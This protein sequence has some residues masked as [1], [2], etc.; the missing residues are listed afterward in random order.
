MKNNKSIAT[1]REFDRPD[2]QS[3]LAEV[4]DRIE[5]FRRLL[6]DEAALMKVRNAADLPVLVEKKNQAIAELS[7]SEAFLIHLFE[8]HMDEPSVVELREQL[9]ACRELN[10]INKAVAMSELNATRKSLDL[11]RSLQRMDDL[12]LYGAAGKI[13]VVRE[14][15]RLGEA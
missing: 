1:V 10:R 7:R 9:N 2:I 5:Q 12:P 6:A 13:N 14:K 15:R 4:Q 8:A 11:L 3:R